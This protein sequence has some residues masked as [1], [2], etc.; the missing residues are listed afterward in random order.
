VEI[1][2]KIKYHKTLATYFAGKPLY[3]DEPTQ[4]KPNTR[5]LVEQPWQQTKGEM[6]DE[7]TNT[8]CNLDFIQAKAAAK[9]TYELVKDFN[10]ALEVIPDN[11]ETIREDKERQARMDKYTQ[12]L[13]ACAKGEKTIDEL[14]IPESITPWTKEQTDA[15][16]ERIK[17]NTN[18][19][20]I[21]KDFLHYL[22][23]EVSNLQNYASQ[24]AYFTHQQAWNYADD[25]PVGKTAEELQQAAAKFLLR[26]SPQTRP[27]WN[28]L[29]QAVKTLKVHTSE[30][31]AV[32]ITPDG[33]KAISGSRDETCIVWDIINGEVIKTLKG[34]SSE[35]YAVAITPDGKKAISGSK[36]NTCIIWDIISG[37][38]IKTLMGHTNLVSAV[39]ILPDGKKAISGSYDNTCILWDIISGEA[40]KTLNEHTDAISAVAITPNGKKAISG[41]DDNTCIVWDIISGEAIKTLGEHSLGVSAVAITPDGKKAITGS[42]DNTCIVWDI[43]SGKAIKTLKEHSK[44]VVAVALT[45]DGKKAISGS[46]DNTCI[47]WDLISGEA[48]KT[49]I[50]HYF[51]VMSVAITPDGKK[52]ISGSCFGICFAW[53]IISGAAIPTLKG[54]TELVRSIAITPDGKK[55]IT[56]SRDETCIVWDIINGEVIK[57]LKGHTS[58]VY[59]IA[60]TPD[61]KNA[62]SSYG[63]GS[64]SIDTT[65]WDII[66]GEAIKTF[67]GNIREVLAITPDG[68]KAIFESGSY[69]IVWDLISGEEIKTLVWNHSNVKTATI[70]PDG[71]RIVSGHEDNTCIVWDL[72]SGEAI[73][74]LRGHASS[75]WAVAITPDGKKAISGSLDNTCI[76]WDLISGE[77]IKTLMGHTSKVY[78]VA[79]T[80]DGKKAISGSNDKTCILWDIATEKQMARVV[81]NTSIGIVSLCSKGV[82]LG[83]DSGEV[84]ILNIDNEILSRGFPITTACRIWDIELN[85]YQPLSADC[86]LCRHRFEPPT[87]VVETIIKIFKAA[88]INSKQS[89]CLEL[90]N[91]AWEHPSLIGKCPNCYEKLKFNPFFGSDMNDIIEYYSSQEREKQFQNMLNKLNEAE[92]A[93][94]EENWTEAY[95][96]YI[97][98]VQQGKFDINYMRYNMAICK[99]NSLF[100]NDPEIVSFINVLIRI[101]Q[102]KGVG[103]KAQLIADKLHAR[104][105]TIKQE[106][107]LKKKAEAPWWRKMF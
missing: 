34:H 102:D 89:P 101:L 15:E 24:F 71:K 66:S 76:V 63:S 100:T 99:I 104:L 85:H 3:L 32:A 46:I 50:G 72:I 4:K 77:A 40:I 43:I 41:C 17:L 84:M 97:K 14:E 47:V 106:E 21:L 22:G 56:G 62:I 60:I 39:A 6:W 20:D 68:K 103:N 80:P 59:T 86:P 44:S 52:A 11:A 107:L 1:L 35:V 75:V 7:V 38:A 36:D 96:L 91:E 93:F 70:T 73:K 57:T 65:Q 82:V 53:D 30:V 18:R 54:H 49:L 29:P 9:M 94:K 95:N 55:A 81:T 23:Q 67:K 5:K 51:G 13:I 8:L 105:E 10:T 28:P 88:G 48:I 12:D 83:C 64:F 33:K 90:P 45:P 78:A 61:G 16:I 19:A 87:S 25:G 27:H 26:R 74:T 69:L 92:K 79:I 42:F 31:Y 2:E 58:D 98:L 37:E